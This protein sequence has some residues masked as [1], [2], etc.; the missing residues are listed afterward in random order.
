[1]R[2]YSDNE[3]HYQM[4]LAWDEYYQS[5]GYPKGTAMQIL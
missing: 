1:M 5:L 2:K 4:L 3:E